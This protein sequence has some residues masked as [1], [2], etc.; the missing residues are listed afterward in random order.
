MTRLLTRDEAKEEALSPGLVHL[1]EN[2]AECDGY[3]LDADYLI[4][5]SYNASTL[6]LVLLYANGGQ[7]GCNFGGNVERAREMV[8]RM[9][10]VS[11]RAL[12]KEEPG[13]WE[14]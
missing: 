10:D 1:P 11:E 9:A 8:E 3:M 4:G 7:A 12:P 13:G 2:G 14:D 6:K 5:L